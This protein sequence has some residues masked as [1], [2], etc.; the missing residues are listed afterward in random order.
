MG[1]REVALGVVFDGVRDIPVH[2][3]IEVASISTHVSRER[4][5]FFGPRS[6]KVPTACRVMLAWS[7]WLLLVLERWVGGGV[8]EQID[9]LRKAS[10]RLAP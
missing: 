9:T 1:V 3:R 4:L 2:L 5:R 8:S 7:R 10:R 6:T